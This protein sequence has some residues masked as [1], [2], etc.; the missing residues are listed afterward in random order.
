MGRI[1]IPKS[2]AVLVSIEGYSKTRKQ[3]KAIGKAVAHRKDVIRSQEAKKGG[4]ENI[5]R[6]K[7]AENERGHPERL[8]LEHE[9]KDE[10][11]LKARMKQLGR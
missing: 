11:G 5:E 2:Y 10:R 4:E 7:C 1:S 6:M 8:S 3:V 9:A